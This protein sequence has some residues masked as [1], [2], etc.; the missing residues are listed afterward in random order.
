M[1]KT[2]QFIDKKDGLFLK[3]LEAGIYVLIIWL[4]YYLPIKYSFPK[5]FD[6]HNIT[7]L[8]ESFLWIAFFGLMVLIVNG[9]FH[10]MK[11]SNTEQMIVM[12]LSTVMIMITTMAAAF[13]GR[14]FGFPRIL[15][16]MGFIL[17]LISFCVTKYLFMMLLRKIRGIRWIM[18]IAD[19]DE[20]ENL[21][22][23]IL[24]SIGNNDRIALFVQ[25]DNDTYLKY[26]HRVNKVFISDSVSGELKDDIIT[27]CITMDKSIYI[28]PKTFEIAIL[29]SDMIQ[30]S[31][32]PTFKVNTLHLSREKMI[33]KR[34]FDLMLSLIAIIILSPI[35]FIIAV[36][37]YLKQGSPVLFRQERLTIHNRKFQLI[38]FRSMIVDAE[39]D[40]GAI[41]ATENDPRV[42]KLGR[43]L[44]KYWLDEL[45]Q[46]FN[47]IKGDMSLVGPRPE[48]PIFFEEFDKDI[49]NFS[50]RLTVKAGVTGLAQVMGK[51]ST[52]PETKIKYDLMYIKN[53]SLLFDIK[54][55]IETAKKIILGTLKR[56]INT[57]LSFDELK[58]QYGFTEKI[59]KDSI[60]FR[61]KK[62]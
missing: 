48:R 29:N 38:K 21:T 18:V 27:R 7:A 51:Y 22:R 40:T 24:S 28:V 26:M 15:I 9:V 56:G 37:L 4:S 42:T 44:R 13:F 25:P 30:F 61:Y 62:V 16:V 36:T 8:K 60:E 41:W 33:I 14:G 39:S 49:P 11:K 58:K 32:L 53:S 2:N 55:I 10:S 45:P 57:E 5:V 20:K 3:I 47:V 43:F 23:K 35:M 1:G 31:D 59:T 50:Y 6:P 19:F 52:Q 46:L 12:A 54:I 34:I 17:Q